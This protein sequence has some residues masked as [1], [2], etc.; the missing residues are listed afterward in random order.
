MEVTGDY[1]FEASRDVV[2]RTLLDPEALKASLPGVER[3]EAT[4]P[5]TFALTLAIGLAAIKGTYQGTVRV[6]DQHPPESYR[7]TVDGQGKGGAVQGEA[8]LTLS[9]APE[10]GTL[11]TYVGTV[12]SQGVIARMGSR[13]LGGAAKLMVGQFMKSME[14]QIAARPTT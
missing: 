1:R 3:F 10:G 9:D 7:L 11:V 13:L 14:A 2:W 8:Q 12:K 6:W 5:E 4:G